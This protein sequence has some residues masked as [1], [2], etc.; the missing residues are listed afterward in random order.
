MAIANSK[1]TIAKIPKKGINP[2]TKEITD[3]DIKLYTNP[4]KMANN[5][6]PD[7]RRIT[8]PCYKYILY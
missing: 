2:N 4:L 6:C 7:N 1:A 5:K 3:I 8:S